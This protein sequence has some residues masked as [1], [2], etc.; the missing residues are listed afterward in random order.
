MGERGEGSGGGERGT[1]KLTRACAFFKFSGS[2]PLNLL[3]R[4]RLIVILVQFRG[5]E[6]KRGREGEGEGKGELTSR[7]DF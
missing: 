4:R 6:E 3:F 2:E 7:Q 1:Y 5:G